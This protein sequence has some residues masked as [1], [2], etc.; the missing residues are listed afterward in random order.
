MTTAAADSKTAR[1]GAEEQ[2]AAAK[3]AIEAAK[4]PKHQQ[5]LL[6]EYTLEDVGKHKTAGD[7]VWVTYKD[8]VYDITDFIAQVTAAAPLCPS[9]LRVTRDDSTTSCLHPLPQA[10]GIVTCHIS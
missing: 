6:P 4:P 2:P 8:G 7:R 9:S 5:Q 1:A 10:S 3:A